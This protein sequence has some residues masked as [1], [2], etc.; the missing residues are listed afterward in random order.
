MNLQPIRISPRAG[1]AR[2]T[3][4]ERTAISDARMLDAAVR[5]I[6][7]RGTEKTTLKDVGELAG[8][9]RG[10]AG[11]R[12]GSK[13]GLFSFVVHAISEE[14]LQELKQATAGKVGIDAIHAATDA[15]YHFCLE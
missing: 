1:N 10:L 7:E 9:S 3:Q 11:Y 5:L 14:W 13:E 8:Y 15:H 4:A 6:V 2:L 12:F